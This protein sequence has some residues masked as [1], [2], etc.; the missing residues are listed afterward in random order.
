LPEVPAQALHGVTA[1]Y[2]TALDK[3]KAPAQLVAQGKV[4]L[5]I[6]YGKTPA[7]HE[8]EGLTG[9]TD[10]DRRVA[11]LYL[12]LDKL[13]EFA[14]K[15]I[16]KFEQEGGPDK[17][18]VITGKKGQVRHLFLF[19]GY[20]PTLNFVDGFLN[21]VGLGHLWKQAADFRIDFSPGVTEWVGNACQ[22][23]EIEEIPFPRGQLIR[24]FH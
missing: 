23:N 18:A 20:N 14:T 4:T 13:V 3:E 17:A 22:E 2:Q 11:G 19:Q 7:Q 21:P 1:A 12:V 9:E 24:G 8:R 16:K 10:P 6:R 15:F 5:Y